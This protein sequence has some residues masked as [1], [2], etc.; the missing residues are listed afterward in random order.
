MG[1][2]YGNHHRLL[3]K[4]MSLNKFKRG[5]GPGRKKTL[6][7]LKEHKYQMPC[8]NFDET[9]VCKIHSWDNWRNLHPD[10]IVNDV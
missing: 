2:P 9:L 6:L 5:A 8:V 7:D 4:S 1:H 10:W 3:E